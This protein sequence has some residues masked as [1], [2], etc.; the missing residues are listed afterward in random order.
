LKNVRA[1]LRELEETKKGRSGQVKEGL[2]IYIG[3]WEKAIQ[4]GAVLESDRV[5]EALSKIEREGGLYAA[6][7]EE[8]NERA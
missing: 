2:E 5:D 4:R 1:Y 7:G 6:A 3:L 8:E